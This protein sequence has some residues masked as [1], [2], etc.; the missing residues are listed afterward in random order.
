MPLAE[1]T[2]LQ[3]RAI[4]ALVLAPLALAA[5]FAGT[6]YWNG[7]IALMAACMAWEWANICGG[8]A[9][10]MAAL[11]TI[12]VAPAV[13]VSGT[14]CGIPVALVVLAIAAVVVLAIAAKERFPEPAWLAGGIAYVGLPC[15]SLEWV[16]SV[17]AYGL[18]TLLWV[19]ALVWATDT[20]A[21]AAGRAVGG[22]K[23]APRISPNKTWAGLIGGSTAAMIVGAAAAIV[24][25]GT[26]AWSLA[27]VSGALA[28]VEQLGDLFE[29]GVKRRFGVKDSSNLIPGHG[30]VLDRVDG[31]LAVS[32]SVACLTWISGRSPL[33]WPEN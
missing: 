5:A 33:M 32:L 1:F 11:A 3:K 12:F 30:G 15:L 22:P 13:I 17:P 24:V 16:R 23:L 27:L 10:S 7:L 4:S 29:S 6:P 8:R 31:L 28:I 9:R 14:I 18:E 2:T 26:H 25:P 20:G 21:Y 19:L